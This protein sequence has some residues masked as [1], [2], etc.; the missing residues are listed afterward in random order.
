MKN[1]IILFSFVITVTAIGQTSNSIE[2]EKQKLR[3]ALVYGD[4]SVATNA[5]YNIIAIEGEKSV[6]IDS[7]AYLYFNRRSHLQCFLVTEDALK[8]SPNN[9]QLLEMSAFSLES[10]GAKDKAIEGYQKLLTLSDNNY[11]A[12][13]VAVLQFE[14]KKVDEA[15]ASIKKADQL[16]DK[17]TEF[18]T[19]PINQKYEQTV[20]LK[21][22]IG[23][24]QGIIALNLE[25]GVDAKASFGRAVQID[26]EFRL[27]KER[28]EALN[29]PITTE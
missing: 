4:Q 15:Y 12:Y 29:T 3:K 17:G 5:M 27:A 2:L 16:P 22:A 14:I 18:I 1:L 13:K 25:N 6:Y 19:F 11:Y 9:V 20:P 28:L 7:L 8:N 24:I 23:Y 10:L 26:P 21:A